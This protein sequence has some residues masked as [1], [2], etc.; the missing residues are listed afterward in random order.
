[1]NNT[2]A[3]LVWTLTLLIESD[4]PGPAGDGA[5]EHSLAPVVRA[6]AY[7]IWATDEAEAAKLALADVA[8]RRE[9]ARD[10]IRVELGGEVRAMGAQPQVRFR[11]SR[12]V[13]MH[14]A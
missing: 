8:L 9:K 4:A 7:E 10:A 2:S 6:V 3:L 14:A 5:S 1:M 11:A 12:Q 13:R